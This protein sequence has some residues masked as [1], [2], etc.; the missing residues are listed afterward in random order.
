MGYDPPKKYGIW[1][2]RG[3]WVMGT[4]S[5]RTKLVDA[6]LYGVMGLWVMRGSTV[7]ILY[8]QCIFNDK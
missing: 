1:G 7:Y 2:I 4:K 5:L 6:K 3:L 8:I